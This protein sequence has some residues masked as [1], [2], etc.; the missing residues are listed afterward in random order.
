MPEL[1]NYR[2]A[3]TIPR[4]RLERVAPEDLKVGDQIL[5]D[6]EYWLELQT[7]TRIGAGRAGPMIYATPFDDVPDDTVMHRILW[8]VVQP[9][10]ADLPI[11]AHIVDVQAAILARLEPEGRPRAVAN[12][13][14]EIAALPGACDVGLRDLSAAFFKL[15]QLPV[16]ENAAEAARAKTL[17]EL[18]QVLEEVATAADGNVGPGQAEKATPWFAAQVEHFSPAGQAKVARSCVFDAREAVMAQTALREWCQ[19]AAG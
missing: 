14:R 6:F 19:L 5:I 16:L 18:G 1:I 9:P 13:M 11:K 15:A 12:S 8:R 4:E 10:P 7:V 17:V 2:H 3:T